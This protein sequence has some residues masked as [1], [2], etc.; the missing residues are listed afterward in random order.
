V[1]VKPSTNDQILLEER[2]RGIF[3]IER[4][5]AMPQVILLL[6]K[7]LGTENADA[8]RLEKI[9]ESDMALA[10]KVLN[11]ANSAFYG[12]AQKVTTVERAIVAVGF[13][14]LRLLVTGM[15]LASIF[16]PHSS[17]PKW[18]S[19]DFWFHSLAVSW[20]AQEL[21]LESGY[22]DPGEVMVAGLL[23]DLGKL[24]LATHLPADFSRLMELVD[25]GRPYDQAEQELALAH[26]QVG[27]WLARKWNLPR[28]HAEVIRDHH[29]PDPKT[30]FHRPTCLIVLAD[31]LA[32]GMGL[33][34]VQRAS[35]A[36]L[37]QALEGAG[38]DKA[39]LQKV[40][41]KAASEVPAI[42]D[43]WRE[44]G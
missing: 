36:S 2:R 13:T 5:P 42:L 9:L 22:P 29:R 17:P 24:I 41:H 15:G 37:N 34:L 3:R 39:L 14:E 19:M 20:M 44:S 28:I 10:S 18:D 1:D 6:I 26:E 12:F 38:L 21:A 8:G 11:L 30:E 23:H 27:F 32:K 40:A 16:E 31:S 4:L 33:G 7:E 43:G 35:S 25:Q